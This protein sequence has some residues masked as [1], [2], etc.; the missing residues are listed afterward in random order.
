MSDAAK[1]DL[2][3]GKTLKA[4]LTELVERYGWEELASRITINCFAKDPSI[5]SS[6]KF[7]R[8]TPWAR[9]KL[10]IVYMKSHGMEPPEKKKPARSSVE[11]R[12]PSFSR[13]RRESAPP[14]KSSKPKVNPW[15]GKPF[16]D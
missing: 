9:N 14:K 12:Q 8:K 10:E 16:E 1:K 4:M 5:S 13:P 2:M 15:T 6:L 3:H 7:L 11:P